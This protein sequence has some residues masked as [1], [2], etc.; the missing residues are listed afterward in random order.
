MPIRQIAGEEAGDDTRRGSAFR[1]RLLCPRVFCRTAPHLPPCSLDAPLRKEL[2]LQETAR[3]EAAQAAARIES[4]N[5]REGELQQKFDAAAG[6]DRKTQDAGDD[7]I[8]A[9][10]REGDLQQAFDAASGFDRDAPNGDDDGG[11]A[12]DGNDG[13]DDDDKG[14]GLRPRRGKGYGYRRGFG[15]AKRVRRRSQA[16]PRLLRSS[17]LDHAF[18]EPVFP[19]NARHAQHEIQELDCVLFQMIL[20]LRHIYNYRH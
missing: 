4:R 7:G 8:A 2:R 17:P 15:L 6:F 16:L 11:L 10:R 1:L 13:S 3:L 12:P 9:D 18:S 14:P 19:A 20:P 5:W